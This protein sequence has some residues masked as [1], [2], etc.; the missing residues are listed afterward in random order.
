MEVFQQEILMEPG[1][2]QMIN[3]FREKKKAKI[4]NEL[5]ILLLSDDKTID[6]EKIFQQAKQDLE[7][8]TDTFSVE[9]EVHDT[10]VKLMMTPGKTLAD[11]ERRYLHTMQRRTGMGGRG[12]AP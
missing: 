7:N 12:L 4:L 11:S 2:L 8:G 3:W 9:L 5:N 6:G 1:G 10:L